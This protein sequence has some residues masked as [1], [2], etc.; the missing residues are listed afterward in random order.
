MLCRHPGESI[1][2]SSPENLTFEISGDFIICN[3]LLFTLMAVN[4]LLLCTSVNQEML[5]LKFS[6]TEESGGG[7]KA[8]NY[9]MSPK[10]HGMLLVDAS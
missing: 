3:V 6:Y 9:I 7:R 5:M 2:L 8:N 4:C 10:L 1:S